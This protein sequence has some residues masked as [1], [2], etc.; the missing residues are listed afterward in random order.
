MFRFA[1]LLAVSCF[2]SV[3]LVGCGGG[4]NQSS[5]NGVVNDGP[6]LEIPQGQSL[7]ASVNSACPGGASVTSQTLIAWGGAPASGY[8]WGVTPG[9]TFPPGTTVDPLTGIFHG[10]GSTLIPGNYTLNMTVSDGSTT[11]TGSIPVA[12]SSDTSGVCA[13]TVFE[14]SHLDTFPMPAAVAASG[15]GASLYADGNG[16]TPWTWSLATGT[17]PPGMVID[18]AR[19]VVRG[20]PTSS[21]SG[22][23]YKFTINVKDSSGNSAICPCANYII[24]VN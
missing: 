8:T 13:T 19:G 6:P 23:S 3:A 22:Q 7:T 16:V 17:L 4:S 24:Q 20:T 1:R 15:Y 18:Q 11:A 21:A 14:Q 5:S 9:S 2:L 12:V 10:N